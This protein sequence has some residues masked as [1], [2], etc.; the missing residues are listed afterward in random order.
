MNRLKYFF[1]GCSI[2]LGIQVQAQQKAIFSKQSTQSSDSLFLT[3]PFRDKVQAFKSDVKQ[4][5]GKVFYDFKGNNIYLLSGINLSKQ[6]INAGNYNSS[7]NYDLVN[8]TNSAFKPG[9]YG[10]FRI[11][12]IYKEKHLYSF[13]FTLEKIASGAEYSKSN[14]LPPFIGN[15]SKFKADDQFLNL[16]ISAHYKKLLPFK[17]NER[18]QFYLVAGPSLDTR[19]SKQS[20]DNLVNNNYRRFLIRAD[21]GIEYENKSFYTLFMHYKQG[22][23]SFT[24]SPVATRL[25]TIEIG[26]MIKA[27]DLF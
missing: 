11:D 19:L 10:G 8:Y 1:V 18:S 2:I 23:T 5:L 27:S 22:V 21:I 16:S 4:I 7:F 9:Y 6:Y 15:F 3:H 14:S 26:L 13:G 20:T 25:N 12:G 17:P 24:K